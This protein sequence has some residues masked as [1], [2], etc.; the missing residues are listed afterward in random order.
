MRINLGA[1]AGSV[2]AKGLITGADGEMTFNTVRS[3]QEHN[4][5]FMEW[6]FRQRQP[7]DQTTTAF[8]VAP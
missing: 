4:G 1:G 5:L 2:N 3:I 6:R 7:Q 8:T